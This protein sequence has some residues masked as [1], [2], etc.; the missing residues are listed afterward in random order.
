MSVIVWVLLGLV[1]GAIRED[2]LA[3]AR[4]RP[5]RG[6][7]D[8]WHRPRS[9][10]RVRVEPADREDGHDDFDIGGIIIAVL[11]ALLVLAIY[12]RRVA[13]RA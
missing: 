9:A 3:W 5:D 10:R 8:R 12:E 1:A 13:R 4:A 2:D 7:D 6:H 11:G